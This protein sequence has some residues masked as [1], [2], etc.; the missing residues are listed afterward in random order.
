MGAFKRLV[1]QKELIWPTSLDYPENSY[2]LISYI[3]LGKN[4]TIELSSQ[5]IPNNLSLNVQKTNYMIISNRNQI[6]DMNI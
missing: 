5:I 6:E 2:F 3:T 1:V 4:S